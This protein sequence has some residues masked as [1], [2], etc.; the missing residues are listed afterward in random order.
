MRMV[1][2]MDCVFAVARK[3][4]PEGCEFYR[5]PDVDGK[6]QPL[7]HICERNDDPSQE[8]PTDIIVLKEV[9]WSF[10]KGFYFCRGCKLIFNR[11]DDLALIWADG[12]GTGCEG[13]A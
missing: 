5:A 10:A 6:A 2:L 4:L 3:D 12:K 11:D 1:E 9:T 7:K 13:I 8:C